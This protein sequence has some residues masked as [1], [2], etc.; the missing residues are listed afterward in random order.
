[1]FTLSSEGLALSCEGFT[2]SFEG[3]TLSRE[4]CPFSRDY[5][6]IPTAHTPF[7]VPQIAP[8]YIAKFRE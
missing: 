4:G 7:R 8:N 1:V 6:F 2:L 3:F 5:F